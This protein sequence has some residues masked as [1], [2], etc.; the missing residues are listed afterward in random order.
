MVTLQEQARALGDPT[1][2]E[3]FRYLSGAE[4]PVDVAELTGH[5]GL[6]HNAVRQHLAKLVAAELVIESRASSRGP[7]RPRLLYRVAPAAESRWGGTGPYERLSQLLGE[8][9]RTGAGPEEVG[10]RA[11]RRY[12]EAVARSGDA[13]ADV[14]LLMARQGFEPEPRPRGRL[15]DVVLR[16][17]PFES[18][19]RADPG[20]VCALHLG[21]AQGFLEDAGV[22]VDDLVANDPARA[23]CRLRLRVG[24][25][26]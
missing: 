23:S 25:A 4:G 26:G 22:A 1:R 9:I 10:R 15:V 8:M 24:A 19:A 5:L 12:R 3:I 11:G 21:I 6:H 17:C 2:H 20:T 7:G 14:A 13:V 18:L 16:V